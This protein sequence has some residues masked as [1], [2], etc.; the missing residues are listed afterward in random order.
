MGAMGRRA[1]DGTRGGSRGCHSRTSPSSHH[2]SS[3]NRRQTIPT[4][5]QPPTENPTATARNGQAGPAASS[6]GGSATFGASNQTQKT[7]QTKPNASNTPT[8]Q[9]KQTKQTNLIIFQQSTRCFVCCGALRLPTLQQNFQVR[10]VFS[11]KVHSV[12]F[13]IRYHFLESRRALSGSRV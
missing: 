11:G 2:P 7:H 9:T 10:A 8:K 13:T 3:K 1:A 4:A 5:K 12:S 6:E